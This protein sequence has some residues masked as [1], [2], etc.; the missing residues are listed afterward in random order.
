MLGLFPI[1]EREASPLL[2]QSNLG[3]IYPFE[4]VP[5]YT[6]VE[7]SVRKKNTPEIVNY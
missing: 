7:P 4:Y 3:L 6:S 2:C 1:E 5:S